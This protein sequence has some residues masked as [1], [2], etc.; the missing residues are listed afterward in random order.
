MSKR[1]ALPPS[2]TI[3]IAVAVEESGDYWVVN[4]SG[5]PDKEAVSD[6]RAMCSHEGAVSTFIVS[7]TVQRPIST[8]CIGPDDVERI[9]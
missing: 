5:Q 8:L 7:A 3:R 9:A 6:A 2:V 1:K 4:C